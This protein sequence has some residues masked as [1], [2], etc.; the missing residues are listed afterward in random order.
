MRNVTRRVEASHPGLQFQRSRTRG[1]S[2]LFHPM[3]NLWLQRVDSVQRVEDTQW[4]APS[5]VHATQFAALQNDTDADEEARAA[6]VFLIHL[7]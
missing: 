7:L 1:G 3:R 4:D 5:S 6:G 2:L